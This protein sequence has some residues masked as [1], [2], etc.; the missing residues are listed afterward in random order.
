MNKEDRVNLER[1]S[2]L[3]LD[4]STLGMSILAQIF[5]GFGARKLSKC[6][7]VGDAKALLRENVVDLIVLNDEL[8]GEPGFEVVRWLRRLESNPNRFAAAILLSGHIRRA[9][10]QRTRDCGANFLIT[11]PISARVMLERVLWVSREKR[12]FLETAD[13]A[14]PDRRHHQVEGAENLGRRRTDPAPDDADQMAESGMTE[15]GR[16]EPGRADA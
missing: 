10:V 14:G 5:T 9:A 3:L 2:I 13:Y 15:S 11:K 1:A 4:S 6:W 8:A 16:P 12:P 7:N